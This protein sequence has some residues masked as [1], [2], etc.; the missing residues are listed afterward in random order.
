MWVPTPHFDTPFASW[1]EYLLYPAPNPFC[2]E[3]YKVLEVT[4]EKAV[5]LYV[6]AFWGFRGLWL[7]VLAWT[8]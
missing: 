5:C 6:L 7:L 2:F 4:Q 3:R 8:V 1:R